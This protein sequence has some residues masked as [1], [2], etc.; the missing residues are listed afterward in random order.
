M[1][2]FHTGK[3]EPRPFCCCCLCLR[4]G[5]IEGGVT[6]VCVS[7][8]ECSPACVCVVCVHVCLNAWMCVCVCVRCVCVFE[9]VCACV[10]V[11]ARACVRACVRA[12]SFTCIDKNSHTWCKYGDFSKKTSN[13][14][15]SCCSLR[16]FIKSIL[17]DSPKMAQLQTP[18]HNT[19]CVVPPPPSPPPRIFFSLS[20]SSIWPATFRGFV[21]CGVQTVPDPQEKCGWIWLYTNCKR[22]CA[23]I[24][25]QVKF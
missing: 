8:C 11:C 9:Y 1:V 23:Y 7:V 20:L 4:V 15:R 6:C 24:S 22:D 3:S 25:T 18:H 10:C 2:C 19:P 16:S 14:A 13:M 5:I 21:G 12:R 17:P